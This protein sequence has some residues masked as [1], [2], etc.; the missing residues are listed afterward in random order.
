MN[1]VYLI[2][3]LG[4][5]TANIEASTIAWVFDRRRIGF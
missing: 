1:S 5:N 2:F 4:L 3:G